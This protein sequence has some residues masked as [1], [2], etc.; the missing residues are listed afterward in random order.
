MHATMAVLIPSAV[1]GPSVCLAQAQNQGIKEMA[2]DFWETWRQK[3]EQ[4]QQAKV[5]GGDYG[6]VIAGTLA[7]KIYHVGRYGSH[8]RCT[9]VLPVYHQLCF[10]SCVL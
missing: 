4:E 7:W 8:L 9:A 10:P 2:A 1:V 3:R 5:G 6:T